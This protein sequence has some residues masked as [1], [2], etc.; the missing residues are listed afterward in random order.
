MTSLYPIEFLQEPISGNGSLH[1]S[2]R[3]NV[4]GPTEHRVTYLAL[5][6]HVSMRE[7]RYT[8]SSAQEG[9]PDIAPSL[10]VPP[11][12]LFS[13][14]FNLHRVLDLT[15]SSVRN[16]LGIRPSDL[17]GHWWLDN[18]EGQDSDTQILSRLVNAT[19]RFDAIKYESARVNG[20]TAGHLNVTCYAVFPDQLQAPSFMRAEPPVDGTPPGAKYHLP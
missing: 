2:G 19:N 14:T 15:S 10:A 20:R 5:H 11:V 8:T 4:A 12:A 17:T 1:S 7:L 13:V 9:T 3:F 18:E 6:P 16:A